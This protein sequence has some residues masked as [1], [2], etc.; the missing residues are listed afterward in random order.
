L[1]G[2]QP[3]LDFPEYGRDLFAFRVPRRLGKH[4]LGIRADKAKSLA[5]PSNEIIG[6]AAQGLQK[7]FDQL[8]AGVAAGTMTAGHEVGA[9]HFV[10]NSKRP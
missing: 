9:P 5:I 4:A 10:D 8:D 6:A 7:P 1:F 3:H 2:D